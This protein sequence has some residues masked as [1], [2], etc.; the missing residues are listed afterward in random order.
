VSRIDTSIQ[1]TPRVHRRLQAV[2]FAGLLAILTTGLSCTS[3]APPPPTLSVAPGGSPQGVVLVPEVIGMSRQEAETVARDAGLAPST[4]YV[5]TQVVQAGIVFRQNPAAGVE[6]PRGS[7][8]A[9]VIA[10][11]SGSSGAP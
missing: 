1:S 5:T 10:A 9:L 11:P 7:E 3:S 4:R 6:V 8:L 2:M